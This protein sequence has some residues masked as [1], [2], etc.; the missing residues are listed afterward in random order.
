MPMAAHAL[1]PSNGILSKV[2]STRTAIGVLLFAATFVIGC[3]QPSAMSGPPLPSPVASP[4]L[5]AI[6]HTKSLGTAHIVVTVALTGDDPFLTGMGEVDLVKGLGLMTWT[7]STGTR[8]ELDNE[9]GTFV[10]TDH[11]MSQATR[12]KALADPLAQ[13]GILRVHDI[14]KAPCGSF[15]CTR[16]QGTLPASD[17]AL[18]SL[19]FPATA[20]RPA[21]VDVTVDI[22]SGSRII[23]VERVA[24]DVNLRVTLAD[25][26]EPLDLS[27]PT[28]TP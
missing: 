16:Y 20:P 14:T 1:P 11:W 10:K 22:D 19:A 2:T 13:L 12:T 4:F 17:V 7:D 6:E 28:R 3:G 26:S 15:T 9:R 21:Q 18:A 8:L 5:T 23:A 24:G 27:A 25:F